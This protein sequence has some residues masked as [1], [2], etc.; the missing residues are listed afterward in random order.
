MQKVKEEDTTAKASDNRSVPT[1]VS[2][3]DGDPLK[4]KLF[5]QSNETSDEIRIAEPF[6]K[7]M[8]SALSNFHLRGLSK[9]KRG[10][11]SLLTF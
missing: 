7:R 11:L 2:L 6:V 5:E 8:H 9:S 10:V 4:L 1:A 3:Y